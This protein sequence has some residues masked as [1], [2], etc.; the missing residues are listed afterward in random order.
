MKRA[1]EEDDDVRPIGK[2]SKGWVHDRQPDWEDLERM[3]G[4]E[5]ADDEDEGE[6]FVLASRRR[7]QRLDGNDVPGA[8]AKDR[9]RT[10]PRP[11]HGRLLW[12]MAGDETVVQVED[13]QGKESEDDG[14]SHTIGGSSACSSFVVDDDSESVLEEEKASERRLGRAVLEEFRQALKEKIGRLQARL[15]SVERELACLTPQESVVLSENELEVLDERTC[16][17]RIDSDRSC[18]YPWED[19]KWMNGS[20]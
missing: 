9:R 11:I 1:W 19:E 18:L 20:L 15:G 17:R 2:R 5:D 12:P 4:N 8:P 7:Q 14:E 6:E 10:S 3:G 13:S 16:T